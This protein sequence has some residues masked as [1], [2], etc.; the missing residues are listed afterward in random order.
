MGCSTDYG[1]Q[2]FPLEALCRMSIASASSE[3]SVH[4]MVVT[5]VSHQQSR[6]TDGHHQ[7]YCIRISQA[8]IAVLE[9][10]RLLFTRHHHQWSK[11]PIS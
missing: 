7:S 11:E 2:A 5:H 1:V 4:L 10:S 3:R 8:L 6:T 9:V